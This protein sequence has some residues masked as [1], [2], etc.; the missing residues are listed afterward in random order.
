MSEAIRAKTAAERA[1]IAANLLKEP[2]NGTKTSDAHST[3]ALADGDQIATRARFATGNS[4]TAGPVAERALG[5]IAAHEFGHFLLNQGHSSF[6]V[7]YAY[8]G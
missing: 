5:I 2:K 4:D 6:G 1:T 8:S 3:I 7:F